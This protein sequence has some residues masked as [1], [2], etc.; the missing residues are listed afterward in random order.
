MSYAHKRGET[1]FI[2]GSL[3]TLRLRLQMLQLFSPF[4]GSVCQRKVFPDDHI[5]LSKPLSATLICFAA[6][7]EPCHN[8]ILQPSVSPTIDGFRE[9]TARRLMVPP[10]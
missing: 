6:Q 4:E 10:S 2:T 8:V 3:T 9:D 7:H 5:G 1:Q